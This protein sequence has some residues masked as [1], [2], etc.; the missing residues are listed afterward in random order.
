M[1][2]LVIE[3]KECRC[4]GWTLLTCWERRGPGRQVG[5]WPPNLNG[6]DAVST[7][8]TCPAHGKPVSNVDAGHCT[9]CAWYHWENCTLFSIMKVM[10]WI[11]CGSMIVVRAA[12]PN[13]VPFTG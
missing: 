7:S 6:P 9:L 8:V 3:A 2:L 4:R 1:Y 10:R 11:S 5:I 13:P 12:S